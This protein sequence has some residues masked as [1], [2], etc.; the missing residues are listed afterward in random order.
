LSG[1]EYGLSGSIGLDR[2]PGVTHRKSKD[3]LSPSIGIYRPH[4][5]RF[6]GKSDG[7]IFLGVLFLNFTV[8]RASRL[9]ESL[10]ISEYSE[11][12]IA[13]LGKSLSFPPR[14]M[15]LIYA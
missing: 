12:R 9:P 11:L 2:F 6:D 10:Q 8:R 13:E 5:H 7:K 3:H 4:A 14:A 1:S 15:A